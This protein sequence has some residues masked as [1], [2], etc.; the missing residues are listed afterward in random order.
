[1]HEIKLRGRVVAEVRG[2]GYLQKHIQFSRHLLRKP[3]PSIC[4][5]VAVLDDAERFGAHAVEVI[6]QET[7]HRYRV[8][9]AKIREYG[10]GVNFIAPQIALPLAEWERVA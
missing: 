8:S 9:I 4:F 5:D 7:G 6:D 1:M 3:R 10:F 2:D